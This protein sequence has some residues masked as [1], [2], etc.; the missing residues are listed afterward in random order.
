LVGLKQ[1]S[2]TFPD[3]IPFVQS[4]I[5]ESAERF[6]EDNLFDS[7]AKYSTVKSLFDAASQVGDDEII[8]V[9]CWGSLTE[10]AILVAHYLATNN[11]SLLKKMRFIAHWIDSSLHQ[12]NPEHPE[13]VANCQEDAAAPLY[14]ISVSTQFRSVLNFGQ[15]S[16]SVRAQYRSKDGLTVRRGQMPR[17]VPIRIWLG[18]LW[19]VTN[20]FT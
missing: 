12:G 13:R 7:L 10:P 3:K 1:R 15:C 8:N 19:L 18:I 9:L 16:I 11:E 17:A 14:S 2:N 4:F 6:I 20:L 5:K